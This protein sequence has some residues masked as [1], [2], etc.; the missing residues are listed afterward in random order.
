MLYTDGAGNLKRNAAHDQDRRCVQLQSSPYRV[1]HE[2]FFRAVNFWFAGRPPSEMLHCRSA[3]FRAVVHML[4]SCTVMLDMTLCSTQCEMVCCDLAIIG[5]PQSIQ[6]HIMSKIQ[7]APNFFDLF[8]GIL[9]S[10]L[11]ITGLTSK[12]EA[13]LACQPPTSRASRCQSPMCLG[14]QVLRHDLDEHG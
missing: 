10:F 14:H 13:H 3:S 12:H 11:D 7:S 8:F 5:G 4:S 2:V 1:L 6:R 9:S